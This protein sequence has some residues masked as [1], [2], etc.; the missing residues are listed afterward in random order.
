MN[1]KKHR[2]INGQK[3]FIS[4]LLV[5]VLLPFYGVAAILEEIARYE[6]GVKAMDE[7]GN[8]AA[9]STLADK[10]EFLYKRFGL[11]A[12]DQSSTTT[13]DKTYLKYLKA[14][15]TQ[16]TNSFI[17]N[18][19]DVSVNGVYSLGDI[20]TLEQEIMQY[21]SVRMPIS[22]VSDMASVD[23]IIEDLQEKMGISNILSI[24]DAGAKVVDATVKIK[25][26]AVDI[27]DKVDELEYAYGQYTQSFGNWKTAMA[28]YREVADNMPETP[29]EPTISDNDED[30]K[31]ADGSQMSADE[32]AAKKKQIQDDYDTKKQAVKEAEETRKTKADAVNTARDD[33][34]QKT[35]SLYDA[36][37]DVDGATDTAIQEVGGY[38]ESA[39]SAVK[40]AYDEDLN[41]YQEQE[42]KN[43]DAAA[44][45]LKE[46]DPASSKTIDKIVAGQKDETKTAVSNIQAVEKKIE[47]TNSNSI[48]SAKDTLKEYQNGIDGIMEAL[49]DQK[50]SI[51]GKA[52]INEDNNW[53]AYDISD[54]DCNTDAEKYT[55][56]DYIE[57]LL[58]KKGAEASLTTIIEYI[59][60][61]ALCVTNL[62]NMDFLY[63]PQLDVTIEN[64]FF[65][66]LPSQ[67]P[68]RQIDNN[69]YS[70][71]DKS[72][73]IANIQAYSG[74]EYENLPFDTDYNLFETALDDF[75]DAKD[76]LLTAIHNLNISSLTPWQLFQTV[77]DIATIQL[78]EKEQPVNKQY[79]SL[80]DFAKVYVSCRY[81]V[82][83]IKELQ[84][85]LSQFTSV[86][87]FLTT[88][89]KTLARREIVMAYLCYNL[90]NR[91]NY[92]SYNGKGGTADANN[93]PFLA[94]I[95]TRYP[96]G[97][98]IFQDL[99]G[100]GR[101]EKAFAGCELEYICFGNQS[102]VKNQTR[103]AGML[104]AIR[105]IA[106]MVSIATNQEFLNIYDTLTGIFPVGTI[107]AQVYLLLVV[108]G[109][110]AVDTLFLVNGSDI[111]LYKGTIYLTPS[112]F[113]K[114]A[115]KLAGLSLSKE[116]QSSV[117][118]AAYQDLNNSISKLKSV[119]PATD[120]NVIS[121]ASSE[122]A[123]VKILKPPAEEGKDV[124]SFNYMQYSFVI[125][126][127]AGNKKKYLQRLQDIIVME[128]NQNIGNKQTDQQKH[129]GKLDTFDIDKAYT[130]LRTS[131]SGNFRPVL[132]VPTISSL[133]VLRYENVNYR[134]F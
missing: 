17:V 84:G 5:V 21:G 2:F 9:V 80:S 54:S 24:V 126:S 60:N 113:V 61:L 57:G 28:E 109:E 88:A 108:I 38:A 39:V 13:V 94:Y 102:E 59:Q 25:N 78:N 129:D 96:V 107:I 73:A 22:I 131:T 81:I 6:S 12:L 69:P 33:Y 105:L 47:S 42:E 104:Y 20:Y 118:A 122:S 99:T 70:E 124:L 71:Q 89:A 29:E 112:G 77:A 49:L 35:Q 19:S 114:F 63:D 48:D 53:A 134:G 82:F 18:D 100:I 79:S 130:C 14:Q 46:S 10:D 103:M 65:R 83:S 68:G 121:V 128:A 111:P 119:N 117:T 75:L 15:R 95:R 51:T 110:P 32:I 55:H 92:S 85:A 127:I 87:D 34:A 64:S 1:R 133:G 7:A 27:N 44:K 72:V 106:D 26:A 23:K 4:L 40:T 50:D 31:N 132:P 67:N 97:S 93:D 30:Y 66:G 120:S 3:G 116:S 16:G 90:A 41:N 91:T 123:D 56:D 76:Q 58:V 125:M 43:L 11:L 86:G 45:K 37:K 101:H 8:I 74:G 98:M 115:T 52:D 62:T 36:L